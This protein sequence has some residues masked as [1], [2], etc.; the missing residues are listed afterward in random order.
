MLEAGDKGGKE[1]GVDDEEFGGDA[2]LAGGLE[3][4][5]EEG[6]FEPRAR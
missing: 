6:G 5:A 4:R 2:A 3:G 1:G